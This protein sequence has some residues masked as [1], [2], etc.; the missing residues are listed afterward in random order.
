MYSLLA[1]TFDQFSNGPLALGHVR[2]HC[3]SHPQRAMRLEKVV[4][5]EVQRNRSLEVLK[6]L[7]ESVGQPCEP[8]A[9]HPQRKVLTL[10]VRRGNAVHIRHS[11]NDC[12]LNLHNVSRAIPT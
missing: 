9:V 8:S 1:T 5:S 7:A 4:M 2:S 12:P 11:R 10:D 6:F 3:G